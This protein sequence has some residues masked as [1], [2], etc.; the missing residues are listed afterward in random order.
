MRQGI[1][2]AFKW[3]KI[4]LPMPPQDGQVMGRKKRE[5][6]KVE[7]PSEARNLHRPTRLYEITH[8]ERLIVPCIA[9]VCNISTMKGQIDDED[10]LLSEAR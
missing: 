6:C 9:D 3:S 8:R 1:Q 4:L 10:N 5:Q 7:V 2:A